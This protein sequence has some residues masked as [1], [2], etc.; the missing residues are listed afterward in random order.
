VAAVSLP[1]PLLQVS[2]HATRSAE[3]FFGNG[4]LIPRMTGFRAVPLQSSSCGFSAGAAT[5]FALC[6]A[7]QSPDLCC[8]DAKHMCPVQAY[9]CTIRQPITHGTIGIPV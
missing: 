3:L 6:T 8:D 5:R 7:G 2:V 4:A 1:W 9:T